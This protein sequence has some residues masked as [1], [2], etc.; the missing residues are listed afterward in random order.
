MTRVSI[1]LTAGLL[2][3]A[4]QPATG[5]EATDT[6]VSAFVLADKSGDGALDRNEFKVFVRQMA[7]SGQRTATRIVRFGAF[8]FAFGVVDANRDGLASPQELRRADDA[9]TK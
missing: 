1:L 5:F 8:G 3:A 9:E 7:A 6:E 2:A 4:S